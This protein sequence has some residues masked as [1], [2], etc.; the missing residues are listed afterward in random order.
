MSNASTSGASVVASRDGRIGHILLDRPKALNALDLAMI[1]GLQAA[2]DGWRDDPAVHAVVIEGAGGRAFCAGGDIRAVRT[3]ALAGEAES[4]EAFFREEYALN[5]TIDEYPKPYVALIDGICMGGGIGVSVHGQIRVTT[6]AGLFAMPE[7]AIAMLPDVGATFMLPRLPGRL[8]LYLGLTGARIQGADAVHAG[9]ATHFVPQADLPALRADLARD[10]VAAV[11][12]HARSLPAFSLAP[13]RAAI[14]RCFGAGSVAEILARLEQES[15]D[16]ARETVTTLR[17][18]SPSSL[19]W[20]FAA[21]RRGEGLSLRDALA[22]ELAMTR[23]VTRHPDF[24]EGVRAMVVDKDRQPRWS[25]DRIES[26]D[27]GAIAA[28]LA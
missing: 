15:T 16:W 17:T 20:S 23:H 9:I 12:V 1:R 7:T 21:L 6:E 14:D 13:H 22:A 8:G 5:A 25:P 26:V 2:L 27:P 28:M 3:H 18:V 4:V 11:A 10:G 24:A 19:L